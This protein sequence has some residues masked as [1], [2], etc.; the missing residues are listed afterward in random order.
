MFHEIVKFVF[1]E[2]VRVRL[3]IGRTGNGVAQIAPEIAS[4]PSSCVVPPI[5]DQP[6][7]SAKSGVD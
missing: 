3:P 4:I 1:A 6:I 7:I 2:Y 5:G